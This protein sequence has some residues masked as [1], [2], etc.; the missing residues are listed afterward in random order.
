MLRPRLRNGENQDDTTTSPWTQWGA[1]NAFDGYS[2]TPE[3]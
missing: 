1:C 2:Q 3:K